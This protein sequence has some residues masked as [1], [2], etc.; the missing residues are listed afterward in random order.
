M[1]VSIIRLC[2]VEL[3]FGLFCVCGRLMGV[4]LFKTVCFSLI[5]AN[6]LNPQGPKWFKLKLFTFRAIFTLWSVAENGG[7]TTT[8]KKFSVV[9]LSVKLIA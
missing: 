7:R 2:G 8:A 5:K 1:I 6:L 9:V 4:P 3:W